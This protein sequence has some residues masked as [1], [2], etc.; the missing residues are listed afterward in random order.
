MGYMTAN[1]LVMDL[2]TLKHFLQ[3]SL[4]KFSKFILF[5]PLLPQPLDRTLWAKFSM[6]LRWTIDQQQHEHSKDP[7]HLTGPRAI[8]KLGWCR[9]DILSETTQ[10][11][12]TAR[13]LN[14]P[15]LPLQVKA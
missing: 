15:I 6:I 11:P 8:H 3:N 4:S 7:T 9:P 14:H 2:Q 12:A 1:A 10:N 13:F 5:P